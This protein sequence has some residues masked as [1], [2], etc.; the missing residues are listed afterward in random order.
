M[1]HLLIDKD[2]EMPI[3]SV[4]FTIN[5]MR[6]ILDALDNHCDVHLEWLNEAKQYGASNT[7]IEQ[8]SGEIEIIKNMMRFFDGVIKEK[9]KA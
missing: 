6:H 8:R 7:E 9:S 1:A 3:Q 2:L 4:D 5:Q